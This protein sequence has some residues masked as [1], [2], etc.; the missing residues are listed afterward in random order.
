MANELQ[1]ERRW[2]N[3]WLFLPVLTLTMLA[4]VGGLGVALKDEL[5]LTNRPVEFWVPAIV[6]AGVGAFIAIMLWYLTPRGS[7]VTLSPNSLGGFLTQL[8]YQFQLDTRTP[9]EPLYLVQILRPDIHGTFCVN[10]SPDRSNLW[11][12][13]FLGNVPPE[14]SASMSEGLMQ[15]LMTSHKTAPAFFIIGTTRNLCFY[16]SVENR[17]LTAARFRT[18]FDEF[19]YWTATTRPQWSALCL[20]SQNPPAT[21]DLPDELRHAFRPGEKR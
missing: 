8:G 15:I 7:G 19:L 9:D 13:V 3:F 6:L 11:F 17:E 12:S 5:T 10:L 18:A 16:R 14:T 1:N 20:E 2:L 21:S 4:A